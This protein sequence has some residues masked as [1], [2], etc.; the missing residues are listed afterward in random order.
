MPDGKPKYP[1][2]FKPDNETKVAELPKGFVPDE[3]VKKNFGGD[4]LST[5]SGTTMT[6]T[7]SGDFPL[8]FDREVKT[9]SMPALV[10]GSK[11]LPKQEKTNF[12]QVQNYKKPETFN[13]EMTD[14]EAK[15]EAL[16]SFQRGDHQ[17][18]PESQDPAGDILKQVELKKYS[19]PEYKVAKEK[20]KM[21]T[22]GFFNSGEAAKDYLQKDIFGVDI[23]HLPIEEVKSMAGNNVT[24]Q[25]AAK[26]Y[27]QLRNVEE[28]LHNRTLDEAS[29]V[30]AAK[31]D[32]QVKFLLDKAGGIG[33]QEE[34]NSAVPLSMRGEKKLQFLMNPD[35]KELVKNNPDLKREYDNEVANFPSRHPEFATKLLADAIAKRR[36]EMG[37]N[38]WFANVVGKENTDKIVDDLIKEGQ[39]P[40]SYKY[41]YQKTI[42]PKLGTAQSIGRGVG[43]AIPGINQLVNEAPIPTPGVLENAEQGFENF[44]VGTA[45]SIAN[46]TGIQGQL[47][48]E[49][50]QVFNTLEKD[51]STPTLEPK[52]L[53]HKTSL[54]GGNLIGFV[55]GL[56]GGTSALNATKLLNPQVA[57]GLTMV[58]ATHGDANERAKTLFPGEKL[59][60]GVYVGTMD[61]LNGVMGKYL[62]G[63]QISKLLKPQENV[64]AST[65]KK[66]VDGEITTDAAKG[67]ITNLVAN[68]VKGSLKGGE[69]MGAIAGVDDLLTQTL[70]GKGIDFSQSVDKAWDS[71]KIGMLATAPLSGMEAALKSNKPFR[72]EIISIADRPDYYKQLANYE[73]ET[74]PDF[75]KIKDQVIENIDF[76]SKVKEEISGK[77]WNDNKKKDYIINSLAERVKLAKAEAAT[78]PTVK[79]QLQQEAKNL[80]EIKEG[81][82]KGI[83]EDKIKENQAIREVKE[84]YNEGYLP[85]GSMETLESKASEEAKPKFDESKVRGYLKYVAEQSNNIGEDGKFNENFDSRKAAK[86]IP[87][88]I[89]D[90]ANEMFPEYSKIASEADIK[91][92]NRIVEP[93]ELNPELPEGFVAPEKPIAEVNIPEIKS[94]VPEKETTEIPVETETPITEPP[95]P[96]EVIETAEVKPGEGGIELSHKGLQEI[97]NEFSLPDVTKRDTKTDIKLRED[98]TATTNKW[99]SD[100]TY[101]NNIEALIKKAEK[102]DILTDEE[103]I[104]LEGHLANVT[105]QLRELNPTS[106]EFEV[107]L[108]EIKRLKDA[109]QKTRSAAGAALRIPGGGSRPD[110]SLANAMIA[111]EEANDNKPLSDTQK[112]Q[113]ATQYEKID[114][115][116]KSLSN[117]GKELADKIRSLRPKTNNVQ[118]NFFGLPIAIYDTSLVIVANAVEGGAKLAD[119]IQQGIKHIKENG[120]FKNKKDEKD[121]VA[122][123]SGKSNEDQRLEAYKK[124]IRQSIDKLRGKTA[125]RDFDKDPK[126]ILELDAE[127]EQLRKEHREAKREFELEL[128]K[129]KLRNRPLRQKVID[130]LLEPFRAV[131]TILTSF[132]FSAPLRQGVV[133]TLSHPSLAAKAFPEMFKQAFSQGRFDTWLADLKESPVY[134]IMD[135]S[136]LYIADPN[137]LHL[138][139]KEEQFMSNIAEKIPFIGKLIK[140]SERA[141]VY[142]LNKM[143]ADLFKQGL[144]VFMNEGKTPENSPELYEGLANYINNSTGRGKLGPLEGSAQF[145]NS[146]FFSPR[147][148]ASR[149]NTLG[150]TD[151]FTLGQSGFYTKLPPEVRKMAVKDMLKFIGFGVSVLALAK[152]NGADVEDDPRSSDFGKIK[153]GN[154]RWDIWGGY[155]P[156]VRLI[157]QMASGQSK[158][159]QTGKLRDLKTEEKETK[160][161]DFLRG[162]LAPVPSSIY[163]LYVGQNIVGEPSTIKSEIL[164]SITP[165]LYRDV[166]EAMKDQGV[167]ALFTV[168][169]PSTFGIGTNTYGGNSQSGG[170]SK[171]STKPHYKKESK[172]T[173]HN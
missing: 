143:R 67:V 50:Q 23:N 70:Q 132:D 172:R 66:M 120:G 22:E 148:M 31:T 99:V 35:V 100:G 25:L 129:D 94:H 43:N 168:G 135:K 112:E 86:Q 29:L 17:I 15:D 95:T 164:E 113:V 59:K 87:S 151:A 62:P 139:A 114:K 149:I 2:G 140:G 130:V 98:A 142:Y 5:G 161:L 141:Y 24:K 84:M 169:I 158:S 18:S 65:L 41:L 131:R 16:Q 69:F 122:F 28:S 125:G 74:N 83:P 3:S 52:S 76:V 147:L 111:K 170:S 115:T 124:R 85:K 144:E 6:N 77:D 79:K 12:T 103:R 26:R 146:V 73:A 123:L 68:T 30:Y 81:A 1:P 7:L 102:A 165:M 13:P 150:L 33:G 173:K 105:E 27:E 126:S 156:Y 46:L 57:Q 64:I 162:K 153:S 20:T 4:E 109:G 116:R 117:K 107:K 167:K 152:L 19:Y 36:E 145:L 93:I 110:A 89:R 51:Y 97:A 48:P 8:L 21:V 133:P 14:Q 127:A 58:L 138:S 82:L 90:L 11:G 159:T 39:F 44:Q 101:A 40:A 37:G 108:A 60:Q 154:T 80:H 128:Q 54:H 118:S 92:A 10:S 72:N 45:K 137:N 136:G 56:A 119:A 155:Q 9:E 91:E 47:Q 42:R 34:Y 53:L 134:E 106:N 71:F 121:Y 166:Q 63:G 32:P 160:P 88:T 104:I 163:D 61:I 49:A 157:S 75:A 96:P 78:D 38:N 55:A 171:K